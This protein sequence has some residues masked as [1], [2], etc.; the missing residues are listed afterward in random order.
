MLTPLARLNQFAVPSLLALLLAAG[1]LLLGHKYGTSPA[2]V[3]S[4]DLYAV[5]F[6]QDL[7][8]SGYPM[9]GWHLPGAPYL[10]PDMALLLPCL[11]LS[12][13]VAV[14]FLAYALAFNAALVAVVFWVAREAGL[15]RRAAFL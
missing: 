9:S 13:D 12:S 11:W 8:G 5:S 2:A 7:L 6:C 4:D 3:N 10:F 1:I 14:A 15:A